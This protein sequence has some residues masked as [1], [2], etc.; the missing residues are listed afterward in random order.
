MVT[1]VAAGATDVPVAM[2]QVPTAG[3]NGNGRSPARHKAAKGGKAEKL[4][5]DV[6]LVA[7]GRRPYTYGLGLENIGL[8]TD[9]RGRVVIDSEYRTKFPH[10]RVIGDCTFGAMLAHK[11]CLTCFWA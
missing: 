5:A 8:E 9:E 11:V 3:A 1:A 4:E 2:P 6:V 10:I 7:I